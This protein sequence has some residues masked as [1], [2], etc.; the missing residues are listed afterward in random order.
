M[1][2]HTPAR[3]GNTGRKLHKQCVTTRRQASQCTKREPPR[4]RKGFE[5]R[6]MRLARKRATACGAG[7]DW[8]VLNSVMVNSIFVQLPICASHQGY[9]VA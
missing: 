2:K 4:A 9:R 5:L 8:T 3:V 7:G 6:A 1:I